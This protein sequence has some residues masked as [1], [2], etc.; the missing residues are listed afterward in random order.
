VEEEHHRRRVA[1]LFLLAGVLMVVGAV[2]L[3]RIVGQPEGAE[4]RV[5]I[6]VG[7]ADRLDRGED[8]E[9]IPADLRLRLR[10]RLVVVNEDVVA[11]QVGPYRVASGQTLQTRLSEAATVEGFCSLHPS[12]RITIEIA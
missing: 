11:H 10:D 1:L 12:G 7:T 8:V 3:T 5:V 4:R 2:G 6:P 9:I